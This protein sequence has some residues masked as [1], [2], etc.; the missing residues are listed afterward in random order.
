MKRLMSLLIAFN[1]CCGAS[2]SSAQAAAEPPDPE[3]VAQSGQIAPDFSGMT[4]DNTSISLSSLRGRVVVL[5]FFAT[6]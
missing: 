5:S 6:W 3:V 4:T 1:L 2:T